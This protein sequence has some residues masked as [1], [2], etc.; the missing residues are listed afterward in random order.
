MTGLQPSS[1]PYHRVVILYHSLI[2][3]AR[4]LAE[5]IS[6]RY[7]KVVDWTIIPQ[8]QSAPVEDIDF[9]DIDL[10]F[11]IGGDGAILRAAHTVA[12][13]AIP[14]LGINIGRVGF[15]SEID[16]ADALTEVGWYLNNTAQSEKHSMLSMKLS[17]TNEQFLALNDITVHRAINLRMVEIALSIDSMHVAS[18]RG[19]GLLVSTATGSTGYALT[20]TGPVM[21]PTLEQLLIKPIAAHMSQSGGI[22]VSGDSQIKIAVTCD[23]PIS[24]TADGIQERQLKN[25]DTVEIE[26]AK[27]STHFLRRRPSSAFWENLSSRLGILKHSP[28]KPRD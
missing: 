17:S 15:I 28:G 7:S 4:V 16:A 19:D 24:I 10:V 26:R 6:S 5:R 13:F 8:K 22:I 21:E 25:N 12:H 1:S 11:V 3:E 9:A 18:Y 20:L 14:I 23:K 27:F 2:D